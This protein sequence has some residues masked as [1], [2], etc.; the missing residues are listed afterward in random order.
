MPD[1]LRNGAGP[2]P[3]PYARLPSGPH[4]RPRSLIGHN[5]PV[6]RSFAGLFFGVAFT[7]ACLAIS[8]FLLQRTAFSPETTRSSAAVILEDDA[9]QAEVVR[10]FVDATADTL[11][12]PALGTPMTRAQVNDIV[13]QV[14]STSAGAELLGDLLHDAHAYMI[15]DTD[16]PLQ[17]T[18]PQMVTIVRDE[19]A[20]VLPPVTI[21]VPHLGVLETAKGITSWVVPTT[22]ILAVVFLLLCFLAHPERTALLRTLGL[23]LIVLAALVMVFG[24]VLPTVIPPLL[25]DSPW[26][27]VPPRLAD[28]ALPY[29]IGFSLILIGV[30]LALFVGSARMGRSRRWS[31]PVSTYRYRE[32]RSWS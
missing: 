30:G 22:A 28:E 21:D 17:I 24:Y 19:R 1:R 4:V 25:T 20:A 14:A 13:T 6:R 26:G 2:R 7:C 29:L 27:G 9:V 10:I 3:Q 5:V 31:T 23:G 11:A 18:G 8:G 16:E 32:E 15:G 12:D